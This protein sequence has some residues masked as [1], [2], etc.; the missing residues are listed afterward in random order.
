MLRSKNTEFKIQSTTLNTIVIPN[1][2]NTNVSV[3]PLKEISW[4]NTNCTKVV[5]DELNS[6][7]YHA[8]SCTMLLPNLCYLQ[9]KTFVKQLSADGDINDNYNAMV[10]DK[11]EVSKKIRAENNRLT[12]IIITL[13][14]TLVVFVVALIAIVLLLQRYTSF[15]QIRCNGKKPDHSEV[16]QQQS[17]VISISIISFHLLLYVVAL[18][19]VALYHREYPPDQ[20]INIIYRNDEPGDPFSVFY[21]LPLIVMIFDVIVTIFSFA[22]LVTALVHRSIQSFKPYMKKVSKRWVLFL[23]L[24]SVGPVFALLMHAP[25]IINAYLNDAFYSQSIFIYYSVIISIGFLLLKQLAIYTCL[26]SV[27]QARHTERENPIHMNNAKLILCQ[28]TLKFKRNGSKTV[29]TVQITGGNLNLNCDEANLV[30]ERLIFVN[31]NHIKVGRGQLTLSNSNNLNS[32][33][34]STDSDEEL[35]IEEGSLQVKQ[36]R[37]GDEEAATNVKYGTKVKLA[38]GGTL[39]VAYNEINGQRCLDI[40]EGILVGKDLRCMCCTKWLNTGSG[41]AVCFILTT[42]VMVLL[43]F[44]LLAI[45]ACYFVLIPINMSISN[46]ADR[47]VGIYHSVVII[48]GLLFT[49]RTLFKSE[50]SGIKEAVTERKKPLTEG[51]QD[52]EWRSMSDKEKLDEFYSTVVDIV[53]KQHTKLSKG[54]GKTV[55][56]TI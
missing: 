7:N 26:S 29:Q 30:R 4:G 15:V 53:V 5:K 23:R 51:A 36:C 42:I 33:F 10:A 31:G 44:S 28:G 22:M 46:V 2:E 45:L 48:V 13:Q 49:Y 43:F 47:L 14:V 39:K 24:S 18:D 12:N 17:T 1:Q 25:F 37:H 16:I 50:Q 3:Y 54:N 56:E 38:K 6:S 34:K 41:A 8:I 52:E 32:N 20:E 40:K 19:G 55:K 11:V 27:W 35:H 9:L 21:N